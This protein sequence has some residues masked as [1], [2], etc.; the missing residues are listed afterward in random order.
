LITGRSRDS[1]STKTP[2]SLRKTLLSLLQSSTKRKNC[3]FHELRCSHLK[4]A[5]LIST[6]KKACRG[7]IDWHLQ[8][9]VKM[10]SALD[11]KILT[12]RVGSTQALKN[13]SNRHLTAFW[14]IKSLKAD[15]N[16][17]TLRV[18]QHK[19]LPLRRVTS[20][21]LLLSNRMFSKSSFWKA[22]SS[23]ATPRKESKLM[24]SS[25]SSKAPLLICRRVASLT[26]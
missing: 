25:T 9:R 17:N 6:N 24:P 10:N 7:Q 8:I 19:P 5:T 23:A 1:Y 21:L 12:R 14:S 11:R 16:W 2:S 13:L 15:S 20:V 26:R 22:S 4:L 3:A 18:I